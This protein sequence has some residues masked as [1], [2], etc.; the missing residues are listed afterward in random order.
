YA[1]L[2]AAFQ[3]SLRP[4]ALFALAGAVA[5]GL[6]APQLFAVLGQMS[7]VPRLIESPE[8]I[9]P[10]QLLQM[11]MA[12]NQSYAQPPVSV[13][14]YH[15]HEWGTYVGPLGVAVPALGLLLGRGQRG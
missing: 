13:P 2:C 8:V 3:R 15:W 12:P 10:R 9:G 6:A 14:D 5:V 11:L 4:L 7:D 1:L